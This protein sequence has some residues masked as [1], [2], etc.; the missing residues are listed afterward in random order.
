MKLSAFARAISST[1]PSNCI[2]GP[3]F[4]S[5]AVFGVAVLALACES[6][7]GGLPLLH[8]AQVLPSGVTSFSAGMG[9]NW[10]G[11][12]ASREVDKARAATAAG[13]P[14]TALSA[15]PIVAA[16]LWP[17]GMFPW[18]SMRLGLGSES[19][20]G[21][22]YTGHRTRIDAR[23]ALVFGHWALSLGL[24]AGLGLAHP[25]SGDS[26]SAS[27]FGASEPVSGLDTSGTRSFAFDAPVILGWHSSADIA[28][29]WFGLRPSYEHAYGTL[30][31]AT[32]ST[33][34]QADLNANAMTIGGLFGLA[35]GLRPLFVAMEL[36]V[37][38]SRARGSMSGS[39][40][41]IAGGSASV[42]AI[43]LTPA[44][45]LIWEIR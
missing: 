6:C 3:Q 4:H 24:G 18:V 35:M 32:A 16:S 19:E 22:T 25:S 5:R 14:P 23:H 43:S 27:T 20:T 15:A 41:G 1:T 34:S 2:R 13:L 42:S 40:G 36:S 45:A 29:I 26:G 11:G 12:E 33:T 37:G 30:T 21:A 38:E 9:S 8:P 17:P 10:V 28:R 44:A 39:P 7:G 31:F